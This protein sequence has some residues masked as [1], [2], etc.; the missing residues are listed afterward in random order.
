MNNSKATT[1]A[2]KSLLKSKHLKAFM[3]EC[4][5]ANIRPFV[6]VADKAGSTAKPQVATGNGMTVQE[7]RIFVAQ[8]DSER[9]SS[10]GGDTGTGDQRPMNL[11]KMPYSFDKLCLQENKLEFE[12]YV[13]KLRKFMSPSRY[14]WHKSE[15]PVWGI[16]FA[17]SLYSATAKVCVMYS[18]VTNKYFFILPLYKSCI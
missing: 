5:T 8:L 1:K 14:D 18:N 7:A 13:T 10:G 17:T 9:R 15:M 12:K 3:A 16:K 4:S 2:M 6:M 11:P